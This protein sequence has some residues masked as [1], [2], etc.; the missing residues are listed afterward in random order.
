MCALRRRKVFSPQSGWGTLRARKPGAGIMAEF[1]EMD[2]FEPLVGTTVHFKGTP[3]S[4]PL[5]HIIKGQKAHPN[6]KREPFILI[7]RAP[8]TPQYMPEGM[9]D[10][11]FANGETQA[12]Y[13]TPVHTPEPEFQDYQAVF[14]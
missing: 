12:L 7:F 14:N 5:Q 9:H 6:V 11:E 3:Y 10:C 8:R 1:L 2:Y 13:V 4:M